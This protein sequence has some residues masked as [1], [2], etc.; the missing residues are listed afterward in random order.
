M[1]F[2]KEIN[3]PAGGEY[4]FEVAFDAEKAFCFK[5]L[6]GTAEIFGTE[7]ATGREYSVLGCKLAIF[8]FSGAR[9][10]CSDGPCAVEYLST[11][12]PIAQNALLNLIAALESEDSMTPRVLVLGSGRNTVTR[13][14]VNYAT[15]RFQL[16]NDQNKRPIIVDLDILNGTSLLPGT[17]T[18]CAPIRPLDLHESWSQ[19]PEAQLISYFYGSQSVADNPKLYRKLSEKLG[20]QVLNRPAGAV[21]AVAPA[22]LSHESDLLVDLQRY[23]SFNVILVVGNERLHVT[24]SKQISAVN[25]TI[26]VLK[27]PKSGGIVDKDASFRRSL[28]HAQFRSYFY[29]PRQEFHPFS[30][31]LAAASVIIF[32]VGD[33]ASLAPS[34]A[35][36]L[37]ATRKIDSSRLTKVSE[38]SPAQLLYSVLGVLV[39]GATFEQENALQDAALA[40]M[41]GFVHVLEVDEAK[42]TMTVLSPCAGNLPSKYLL[43]GSLKWIEK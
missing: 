19:L 11:E 18:A 32:R 8:S 35:L 14:L 28:Q 29:G 41:A 42:Q 33:A 31:T 27:I 1:S 40:A 39:E 13:T 5:L 16:Q 34:S 37:G 3:I 7:L 26:R 12:P 10:Q 43:L 22:E 9:L 38:L 36:P 24:V 30:L 21:F 20:E 23:F 25:D 15:R 2:S 6:S 17:L 4:R